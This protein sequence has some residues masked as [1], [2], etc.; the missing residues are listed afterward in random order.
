MIN[1]L[2]DTGFKKSGVRAGKMTQGLRALTGCS[3][4]GPGFYPQH[5]HGSSQLSVTS[6]FPPKNTNAN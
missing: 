1:I 5:S 6:N 2:K 3:S 4:R